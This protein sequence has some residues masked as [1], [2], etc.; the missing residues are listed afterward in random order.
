MDINQYHAW[1]GGKE[2]GRKREGGRELSRVW[3][4]LS[5]GRQEKG[6]G[7]PFPST[8][9]WLPPTLGGKG[10]EDERGDNTFVFNF[11]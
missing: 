2:E 3:L 7:F 11:F 10:K 1:L 4:E 6:K 5:G 9:I 8:T